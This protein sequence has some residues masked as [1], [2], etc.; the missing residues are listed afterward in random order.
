MRASRCSD[1]RSCSH[2]G[3][4]LIEILVSIGVL[5]ILIAILASALAAATTRGREV[6]TLSNM[7][8]LSATFEQYVQ[9]YGAY[10]Y[11]PRGAQFVVSPPESGE[12]SIIEPPYWDLDVYW[13]ALM[14]DI[15]PWPEHFKTW[16]G[17]GAVE[18]EE[19]PWIRGSL[20]GVPSYRLSHTFFARPRLWAPAERDD[21]AFYREVSPNDVHHPSAKGMLWDAELTHLN[22]DA[23]ADRDQRAIAFADGH[24]AVRRMSQASPPPEIPFKPD[25]LPVQ[26]TPDGAR[27]VDY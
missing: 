7:R 14:H 20:T 10:P 16:V 17:P 24:V 2:S 26:D 6:V 25:T 13:T 22:A 11:A 21:A 18:N 8:Q 23:S 15:A 3:F 9:V 12:I 27:G 4:T 19:E 1:S 5:A